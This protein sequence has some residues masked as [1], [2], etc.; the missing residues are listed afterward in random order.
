MKYWL[1]WADVG[2][3][4]STIEDFRALLAKYSPTSVLV[5]C[6]KISVHLNYGPD[7]KTTPTEEL[8]EKCIPFLFPPVLA[9]KVKVAHDHDRVI[10]FQGQLRF[11]AAEVTRQ[12][13][14]PADSLPLIENL[15]LGELFLRAAELL[16]A[17]H[18]KPTDDV[19]S[20]L[21]TSEGLSPQVRQG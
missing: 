21:Y 14:M 3:S 19:M 6:A 15:E 10:F 1:N 17:V 12:E 20:R 11:I 2:G 7:G 8:T 9:A 5:A 16:M 13:P 4:P 18:P